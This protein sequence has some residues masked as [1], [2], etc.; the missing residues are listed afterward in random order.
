MTMRPRRGMTLMELLV[1]I[2]ITGMMTAAG[3][4]TFA[5]VIDHRQS[6]TASTA[7]IERAAALREELD[8][9]ISGGT[10]AIQQG[11]GPRG[12]SS[13]RSVA[14]L[15]T[16][17]MMGGTAP[18]AT[19][20]AAV[21]DPDAELTITTNALTPTLA[22]SARVRVYIDTDGSTPE[23]GLAVEI[24]GNQQT[25][26]VRQE[27][28]STVTGMLVE[29]LDQRTHRWVRAS[30]GATITP[31]AVRITLSGAGDPARDS[32]PAILRV[33]IVRTTNDM[34]SQRNGL[35]R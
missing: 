2:A 15:R 22:P 11:G 4:G 1:A 25:P 10:V 32:L 19:A 26:L 27:L 20:S 24:Q 6:L 8:T 28:D 12:R 16:S 7:R 13:A 5:A 34:A 33:P 14:R 30:E 23:T 3:V 17:S 29:F 35:S 31:M 9:W 18:S 21:S